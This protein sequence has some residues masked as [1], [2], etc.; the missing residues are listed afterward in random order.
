[1]DN[2]NAPNERVILTVFE[3]KRELSMLNFQLNHAIKR[4]EELKAL[5]IPRTEANRELRKTRGG[6]LTRL[7]NEIS[8]YSYRAELLESMLA[9]M[10]G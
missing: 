7:N 3:I 1:M 9:G 6:F 2:Y 10:E 5:D 8:D 4:R